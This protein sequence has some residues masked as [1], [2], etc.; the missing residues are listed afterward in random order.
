MTAVLPY[1]PLFL[2]EG[3]VVVDAG[4]RVEMSGGH[5]HADALSVEWTMKGRAVLVDPGTGSYVGPWRD[6]FRATSAHNTLS[7]ADGTGSATSTGPFRWGRWPQTRVLHWSVGPGW[8][9]LVTEHD[10]F[11]RLRPGLLHRRD[12]KSTRLT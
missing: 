9:V 2:S 3:S 7:L 8:A 1:T 5:S 12:R 11:L 4:P 10:G 6:R